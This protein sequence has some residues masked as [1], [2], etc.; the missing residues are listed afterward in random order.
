VHGQILVGCLFA[1]VS[2]Y[3]AVRFLIRYFETRT[4][5]PF[6]IYCLIAGV[7]SIVRFA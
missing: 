4:L 5:T 7:V 1:A 6:A 3:F 2:A